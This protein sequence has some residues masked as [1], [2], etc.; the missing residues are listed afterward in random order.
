[1]YL[2]ERRESS[3]IEEPEAFARPLRLKS[4]SDFGTVPK[5]WSGFARFAGGERLQFRS[6]V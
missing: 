6:Y 4:G 5:L 3:G 2:A 1:M